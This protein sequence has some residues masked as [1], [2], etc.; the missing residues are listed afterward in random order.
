MMGRHD[1]RLPLDIALGDRLAE[2]PAL[3]ALAHTRKVEQLL[4]RDRR[5]A[6]ALLILEHHQAGGGEPRQRLAQRVDAAGIAQAELAQFQLLTRREGAADDIGAEPVDQH[7]GERA[8]PCRRHACA[9]R[10]HRAAPALHDRPPRPY[11][12]PNH[13]I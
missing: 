8:R 5:D 10:L 12:L 13:N 6:E 4:A 11:I 7:R 2:R 9:H 1:A 3:D